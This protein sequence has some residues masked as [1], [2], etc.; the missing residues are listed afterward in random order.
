MYY[1]YV[2]KTMTPGYM[3]L[4][5]MATFNNLPTLSSFLPTPDINWGGTRGA[6]HTL[7]PLC[8]CLLY[9]SNIRPMESC[10]IVSI[11]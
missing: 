11:N 6:K 5:R 10:D 7:T 2:S 9:M 8:V 3:I 4:Y 1:L